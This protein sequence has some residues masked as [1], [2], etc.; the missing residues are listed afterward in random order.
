MIFRVH[1]TIISWDDKCIRNN[2]KNDVISI[3]TS[4]RV[5]K[6]CELS[7]GIW[8]QHL[9]DSRIHQDK[10]IIGNGVQSHI[11]NHISVSFLKRNCMICHRP[12]LNFV[13]IAACY[14]FWVIIVDGGCDNYIG[15]M[16]C[17][18][19]EQVLIPCPCC[20]QEIREENSVPKV[21]WDECLYSKSVNHTLITNDWGFKS[22]PL[23]KLIYFSIE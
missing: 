19:G 10:Q 16:A 12:H 23:Q 13:V 18:I 8:V 6:C 22:S 17:C 7:E 4:A 21:H 2:V 1:R 20:E 3:S 5:I 14:I 9:N 11:C 15:A